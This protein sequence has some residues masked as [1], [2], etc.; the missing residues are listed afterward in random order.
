MKVKV[1]LTLLLSWAAADQSLITFN[2]AHRLTA[3]LARRRAIGSICS[4][5]QATCLR[6]T[7]AQKSDHICR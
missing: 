6:Q 1:L 5:L 3:P 7:L 2:Q 4:T